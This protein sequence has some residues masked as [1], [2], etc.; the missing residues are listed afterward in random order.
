MLKAVSNFFTSNNEESLEP[1]YK[2]DYHFHVYPKIDGDFPYH[3]TK[4]TIL[5]Y[6][7]EAR[8][9]PISF[10]CKWYRV[11]DGRNFPLK[12]TAQKSTMDSTPQLNKSNNVYCI[13][14]FDLG[15]KIKVVIK[16]HSQY[17]PGLLF[18]TFPTVKL[19]PIL[20]PYLENSLISCQTDHAIKVLGK[21]TIAME[22]NSDYLSRISL[23]K[24]NLT[25]VLSKEMQKRLNME[26]FSLDLV[27]TP[28]LRIRTVQRNIKALQII[29]KK[30]EQVL[31]RDDVLR[32]LIDQRGYSLMGKTLG[33]SIWDD[34]LGY[35]GAEK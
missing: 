4:I 32:G 8:K 15:Y 2:G 13:T 20:K 10:S 27:G 17:T 23:E 33:D 7:S 3:T 9:N 21:N 6:T 18:I 11:R 24:T 28:G 12:I 1:E 26:S 19:D 25:L 30:D 16:S 29:F 5:C 34:Y 14:P 22:D 31:I 35:S